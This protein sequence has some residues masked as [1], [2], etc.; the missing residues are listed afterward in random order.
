MRTVPDYFPLR[1]SLVLSPR[2]TSYNE[3]IPTSEAIFHRGRFLASTHLFDLYRSAPAGPVAASRWRRV[4]LETTLVQFI[5]GRY[6]KMNC[7]SLRM[8][9]AICRSHRRIYSR[10]FFSAQRDNK[11]G[12]TGYFFNFFFSPS[13]D[14]ESSCN[15]FMS[16][17]RLIGKQRFAYRARNRS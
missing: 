11:R 12:Q 1:I 8:H 15:Y 14:R 2:T 9:R 16:I 3:F 13:D 4:T 17:V 7:K 10:F 6:R 5:V